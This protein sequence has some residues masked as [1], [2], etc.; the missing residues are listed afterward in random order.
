MI[1]A[2]IKNSPD[3]QIVMFANSESA[4]YIR[5]VAISEVNGKPIASAA[6]VGVV[7]R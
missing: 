4:H 6:E 1:F 2:N 3:K 5:L 7:T